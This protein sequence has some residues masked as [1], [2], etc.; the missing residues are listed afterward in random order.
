[1][2]DL[3]DGTSDFLLRSATGDVG[4]VKAAAI[5]DLEGVVY[6]SVSYTTVGNISLPQP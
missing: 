1:M 2:L 3:T 6:R 4:R 5:R